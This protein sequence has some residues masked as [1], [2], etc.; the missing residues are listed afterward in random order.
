MTGLYWKARLDI[1]RPG[2]LLRLSILDGDAN[3]R[4][5]ARFLDG[6]I[7]FDSWEIF[8]D[9]FFENYFVDSRID[10]VST[11]RINLFPGVSTNLI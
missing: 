1:L 3:Y 9:E 11:I 5:N 8:R 4:V 2:S 7:R 10:N 6:R